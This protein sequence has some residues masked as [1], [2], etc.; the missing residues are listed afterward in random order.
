MRFALLGPVT[1]SHGDVPVKFSGQ[2]PRKLLAVLLL[3]ANTVVSADQ[4][5]EA[6]WG[7]N[8]PPS[9]TASLY[10]HV[11]RLR[12]LLGE[13]A[14]A[15]I[16][17]VPP[18]YLIQVEP[19][20]L[21]LD[22]FIEL[23]ATGHEAGQG[24][25]WAAAAADLT[26]ALALWRGAPAADAP[27]LHGQDAQLQQ[28]LEAR[29]QAVEG[30]I[31]AELELGRHFDLVGELRAL[32]VAH[33][34]REGFHGQLMLALYRTGRQAEALTVFQQLRRSLVRG[35][36]V[37]PSPAV[38]ELHRQILSADP[39]LIR[40]AAAPTGPGAADGQSVP[41]GPDLPARA[42]A[43]VPAQL[44]ADIRDFTGREDTVRD[45]CLLLA[46]Q[47]DGDRPR[48]V[49][50][51]AV[52]GLGGIGKTTLALHVA[53]RLITHFPDGQLYVN[54]R[55]VDPVPQ[56]PAET[57][58][59]L[60]R[61]L[62]VDDDDIPA[63]LEARAARYR[64][65][66]ADRNLLVVLDN[67]RDTAQVRP[68]LP[69]GGGCA[70]LVTSRVRLP[71]LAGAAAVNL[72]RLDPA[73]A[74][75]LFRAVAGPERTGAEPEAVAE[76]LGY[77]SGLPLAVRIA[78]ARLAARPSWSVAALAA[79]LADERGRLNELQVEDVAVRASFQ[80]SYAN[81]PWRGTDESGSGTGLDRAFRLLGLFPGRDFPAHAAAA[82]FDEPLP[83]AE[84]L[85]ETLVDANLLESAGPGRYRFHD[86]LRVYAGERVAAEETEG[87]RTAAVRRMAGWYVYACKEALDHLDVSRPEKS[88]DAVA[89]PEPALRLTGLKAALAWYEAERSNL[90]DVARLAGA[91]G[92][93]AVAWLI[94]SFAYGYYY[95][96]GLWADWAT[97]AGVGLG[98]ARAAG[99]GQ[100]T[101]EMLSA[102]GFVHR[103][104]GEIDLALAECEE[105]LELRQA[106][107]GNRRGLALGM[108]F[109]A[110]V[111][112]DA[113]RTDEAIGWNQRAVQI[114]RELGD[115]GDLARNLNNLGT[116]Y[117]LAGRHQDAVEC[118]VEGLALA[119][120]LGLRYIEGPTLDSLGE[121]Y[122][123]LGRTREAVAALREAVAIFAELD[124]HASGADS[125]YHL[126]EALLAEGDRAGAREAWDQALDLFS[127]FDQARAA[128]V[129][130]RLDDPGVAL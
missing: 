91:E 48:P 83:R 130:A 6:L 84:D 128:E 105:A 68:L 100:A 72:D 63:D 50:V 129:R 37:E 89:H 40:T 35:L 2:M 54:L 30:R 70:V 32:T 88:I 53:H 26:A 39:A 118:S 119:R 22:E 41:D 60:L 44:P 79:R 86:L 106:N 66:T 21:D 18:G 82:L 109:L 58:A 5:T 98:A 31:E 125:L 52:T 27:G 76:V 10:N 43:P 15:R 7:E 8:P 33:P 59:D 36:A 87:D 38:Q 46:S 4:L 108:V 96:R 42:G 122:R 25:D 121:N 49:V 97:A 112:D 94:P 20:E 23:C 101:A 95:Q 123:A 111:L 28:L 16:R 13:P 85:L 80:M 114:L 93:A 116:S 75:E 104:T 115:R 71:G 90:V 120:E 1:A 24:G 12:R 92:P 103:A 51:S 29:W 45:L 110:N 34:L 19:G 56:D 65:T 78:A 74:L 127:E 3:Q 77:C 107:S 61:E 14:A 47:P 57:L 64:T 9:A 102:L 113:D 117:R 11:M 73:A 62:G 69:G 126:A 124:D 55:G 67:A 17:A 81:L 99:D